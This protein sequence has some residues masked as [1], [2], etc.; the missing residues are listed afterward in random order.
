MYKLKF[1]VFFIGLSLC[2]FSWMSPGIALLLGALI[3]YLNL[4][5]EPKRS[6][7]YSKKILAWSIVGLGTTVKLALIYEVSVD[8][9]TLTV[10]TLLV[11]L[12]GGWIIG[13]ILHIPKEL[14]ALIASGTAICGATAIAAVGETI[15][16][17]KEEMSLALAVILVL[18]AVALFLFPFLGHLLQLS[19]HAFG[20]W[21]GLAIHDTSSV[22]GAALQ[23]SPESLEYATTVKLARA[24]WIAPLTLLFSIVLNHGKQSLSFKL[25]WFIGGFI[26]AAAL[27]SFVPLLTP[28][29][30]IVSMVAR[31]GFVIA[32]FLLGSTIDVQSL[33]VLG[34]KPLL[35]GIL[36][37]IMSALVSLLGIY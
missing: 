34:F 15:K 27:F 25:P 3:S 31:K 36:L 5:P 11:T 13:S 14:R 2:F 28:Y 10:L 22:V 24:I 16:S 33:R 12:G 26:I 7:T 8:H 4:N 1:I 6:Q 17:K 32:I 20:V 21:A 35:F 37:W 29:A 30:N 23:Y 9:F 19:P 18:N